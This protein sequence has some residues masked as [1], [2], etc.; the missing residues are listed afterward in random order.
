MIG[1]GHAKTLSVL[2][3]PDG[4]FALQADSP[5]PLGAYR[6]PA[7]CYMGAKRLALIE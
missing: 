5:A 6:G 3:V 4:G 1:A 2:E 7:C